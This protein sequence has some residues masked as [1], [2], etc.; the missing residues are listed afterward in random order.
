MINTL[1]LTTVKMCLFML[2]LTFRSQES[3][4]R[5]SPFLM[6]PAFVSLKSTTLYNFIFCELEMLKDTINIPLIPLMRM[7]TYTYNFVETINLNIVLKF[8]VK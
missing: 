3:T 8:T 2:T 1:D 4:L 5:Y 6:L 7:Q